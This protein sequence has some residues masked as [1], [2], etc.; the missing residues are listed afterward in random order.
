MSN[1]LTKEEIQ[2][3]VSE[4]NVDGL[5]NNY[6]RTINKAEEEARVNSNSTVAE[7]TN[8]YKETLL[9]TKALENNI[10]PDVARSL[11]G[12]IDLSK[13]D[14]NF[15][16]SALGLAPSQVVVQEVVPTPQVTPTVETT[17]A[18][19]GQVDVEAI[20]QQLRD[21]ILKELTPQPV[22]EE[23]VQPT[24]LNTVPPVTGVQHANAAVT[25]TAEDVKRQSLREQVLNKINNK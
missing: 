11:A 13:V 21:E 24:L 17:I 23:V 1:R 10:S 20:K 5:Y 18:N 19:E 9:I 14:E 8:K 22:V 6:N 25:L 4:G 16:I 7:I 2:A 12:V 3:L 15:D